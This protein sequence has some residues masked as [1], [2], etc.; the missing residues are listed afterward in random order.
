MNTSLKGKPFKRWDRDGVAQHRNL[1]HEIAM[2][3]QITMYQR[4][5]K[6]LE[7]ELRE[8]SKVKETLLQIRAPIR[9][10]VRVAEMEEKLL[11]SSGTERNLRKT[12]VATRKVNV[13]RTPA[14]VQ[15][16]SANTTGTS[17]MTQSEELS[18]TALDEN[19]NFHSPTSNFQQRKIKVL[20]RVQKNT[21]LGEPGGQRLS[22]RKISPPVFL[23]SK[24]PASEENGKSGFLPVIKTPNPPQNCSP[25]LKTVSPLL[26][27]PLSEVKVDDEV[28]NRSLRSPVLLTPLAPSGVD[29]AQFRAKSVPCEL[30]SHP[31]GTP[32]SRPRQME[33]DETKTLTMEETLRIKGKFR[34]IGHSVIATALLKG[35]KQKGQLSS[36]AIH[37]MHKPI[38]LGEESE[39]SKNDENKNGEG[40]DDSKD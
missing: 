14:G 34:Q 23:A 2:K 18:R 28:E 13:T 40:E 39:T 27:R 12:P 29:A 35:L 37:N 30:L 21:P 22:Q 31:I 20:E 4:E 5:V 10:R 26:E 9:R 38:S 25:K 11:E 33:V 6:L 32:R 36:E 16:D 1:M 24:T 19:N 3:K 15:H 17:E 8:I 7:K